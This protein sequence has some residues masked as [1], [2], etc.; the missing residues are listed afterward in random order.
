MSKNLWTHESLGTFK[1]D[2]WRWTQSREF[3]AIAQAFPSSRRSLGFTIDAY[4]DGYEGEDLPLP[5]DDVISVATRVL[6]RLPSLLDLGINALWDDF[7]GCGEHPSGMW[8]NNAFDEVFGGGFRPGKP[9]NEKGLYDLLKP[10]GLDVDVVEHESVG[11]TARITF[12]SEIDEE[13]GISIVTDGE[14]IVGLGYVMDPGVFKALRSG[15]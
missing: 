4:V 9:E 3:P 11:P 14:G 15:T 6:E 10:T 8:W 1:A 13:H 2:D 12:E 7:H 5:T